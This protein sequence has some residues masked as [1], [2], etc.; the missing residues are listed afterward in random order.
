MKTQFRFLLCLILLSQSKPASAGGVG[1]SWQDQLIFWV[2]LFLLL[3]LWL[4]PKIYSAMEK[5]FK[6]HIPENNNQGQ[7][8]V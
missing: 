7:E 2:P 5:K 3:Y 8:E 6:K 1:S 4:V